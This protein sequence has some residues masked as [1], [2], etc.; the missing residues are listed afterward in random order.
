MT[1]LLE[2]TLPLGVVTASLL[3]VNSNL[4]IFLEDSVKRAMFSEVNKSLG[5]LVGYLVIKFDLEWLELPAD[6]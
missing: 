3:E 6:E 1:V 4:P 2:D 5:S